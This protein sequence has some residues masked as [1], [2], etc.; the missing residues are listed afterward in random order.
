MHAKM[1]ENMLD[2]HQHIVYGMDDGAQTK[3]DSLQMLRQAQKDGITSIVGTSHAIPA[4][5]P[6]RRERYDRHLNE[7]NELCLTQNIPVTV[8]EGCEIFFGDGA[9]RQ[10]DAGVLPTLAGTRMV[11]VEFDPL[12]RAEG[13]LQALRQLGNAGYLPVVAHVER[14]HAL[15]RQP[16]ALLEAAEQFPIRI[17]VNCDTFLHCR[18]FSVRRFCNRLLHYDAVDFLATDAHDVDGRR[19]NMT[20]AYQIIAKR[21]S[22][23]KA[24]ELT[25]GQRWEK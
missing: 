22:E 3:E 17:Q 2:I 24:R 11:L 25:C 21:F 6:F 8:Y 15:V 10:L 12:T 7:L 14:Y 5:K 1:P 16:D 13:I 4:M 19:A 20:E 9:I 18:S 23:E